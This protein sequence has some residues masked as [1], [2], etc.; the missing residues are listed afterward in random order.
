MTTNT[1]TISEQARALAANSAASMPAEAV[2]AFT[3]DQAAL[4][5][6][7]VPAGVTVPGTVLPDGDLL[8]VHGAPTSLA[9]LRGGTPAVLVFYRGAWCPYC[10]LA[11]RTYQAELL[12]ALA[13]RGVTLIAV[14]PQTPDGSLSAA[15]SNGLTYAVASD[16]GNQLA[17]ALGILSEPSDDALAAQVSLGLD[18][19][20]V[21]ADGGTTLPMPTVV[22]LDESGVIRWIDVHPNYTDRSEVSNILTAVD[23]AVS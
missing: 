4:D 7:G 13:D 12:P 18:L 21:N 10:N 15:E 3:A 23:D 14:S 17:A 16:P 6:R 1:P 20:E 2:S 5:E 9:R 11:L 19:T 22:V 8:D